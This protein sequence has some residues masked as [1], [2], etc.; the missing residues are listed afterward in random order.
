[1]EAKRGENSKTLGSPSIAGEEGGGED[2]GMRAGTGK[3]AGPSL[4]EKAIAAKN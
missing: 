2:A 1:M 3:K 4:K